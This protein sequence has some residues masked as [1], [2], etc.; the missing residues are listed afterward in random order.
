MEYDIINRFKPFTKISKSLEEKLSALITIKNID[1]GDNFI[2]SGQ[3]PKNLAYV[4]SGLFRDYY[5][6]KDGK[7][8]T[9]WFY[10]EKSILISY[11]AVLKNRKSYFTIQALEKSIVETLNY[12]KLLNLFDKQTEYK[13]EILITELQNALIQKEERE[14]ELLMF[15][16]EHRYKLLLHRFPNLDK[17]VKQNIIASY[18]AIAPESLSRI[19]KHLS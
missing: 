2:Y 9:K 8:V 16:A 4:K 6:N 10:A 5:T 3:Y 18:L 7:E 13:N 14:Y 17:R 15:D 12:N 11:S 1:K 19:K